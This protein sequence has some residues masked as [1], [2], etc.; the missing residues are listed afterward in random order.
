MKD[1]CRKYYC[2]PCASANSNRC[3]LQQGRFSLE[4]F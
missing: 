2:Y 4:V 3:T 1:F